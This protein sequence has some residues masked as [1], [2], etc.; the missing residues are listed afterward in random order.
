MLEAAEA[1]PAKIKIDLLK[2]SG[3]G[4][5]DGIAVVVDLHGYCV[6]DH[7]LA[8]DDEKNVFERWRH[9]VDPRSD[10]I[11]KIGRICHRG[12]SETQRDGEV[13]HEPR[14][15]TEIR[16]TK[17][18]RE[19]RASQKGATKGGNEKS[20]ELREVRVSSFC[21]ASQTG[22][23]HLVRAA[24]GLRAPEWLRELR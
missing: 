21:R 2:S 19:M 8:P 1:S 17:S 24:R 7:S 9:V 22:L 16:K 3:F 14:T 13:R 11:E 5:F 20:K 6:F 15:K 12:T 10:L 23:A 4:G 18:N